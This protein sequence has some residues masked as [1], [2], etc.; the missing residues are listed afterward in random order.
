M[1][2]MRDEE[3]EL[4]EEEL[5]RQQLS[6]WYSDTA[7]E[8]AARERQL[9]AIARLLDRAPERT[10]DSIAAGAR[11]P[12][13]STRETRDSRGKRLLVSMAFVGAAAI[14]GAV[15]I[16]VPR[17]NAR[18]DAITTPVADSPID[19]NGAKLAGGNAVGAET[20]T[21]A[22]GFALQLPDDAGRQVSLAGDFN[23]WNAA[24]LP[25]LRDADAGVWRI[26]IALPPGRHTYSY[27]VD[28]TRWVIDPLAP[29]TDEGVLGPTNVITVE[30]ES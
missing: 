27:V 29:R 5:M 11:V 26:R 22:V 17:T 10:A 3:R 12:L 9:A 6:P 16:R 18:A 1:S 4:P 25:M 21:R 2:D 8:M 15:L 13:A 14:L 23:G 7:P 19:G 28:G 30:G 24:A 20:A